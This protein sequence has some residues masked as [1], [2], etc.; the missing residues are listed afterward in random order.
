MNNEALRKFRKENPKA[1]CLWCANFLLLTKACK[2][3]ATIPC[4][5]AFNPREGGDKVLV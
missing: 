4:G 2:V 3:G 1:Q 5:R